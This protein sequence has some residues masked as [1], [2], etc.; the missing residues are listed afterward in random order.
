MINEIP[1]TYQVDD[2]RTSYNVTNLFPPFK[3]F[4][5]DLF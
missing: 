4:Y 2:N 3:G 5:L 1:G